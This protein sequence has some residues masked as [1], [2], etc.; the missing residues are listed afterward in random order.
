VALQWL[1]LKLIPRPAVCEAIASRTESQT[2]LPW[3]MLA[4]PQSATTVVTGIVPER[5]KLSLRTALPAVSLSMHEMFLCRFGLRSLATA[6][7]CDLLPVCKLKSV[8]RG[9]EVI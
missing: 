7:R 5:K 6:N 9:K 4:I 1:T 3:H 8:L 2:L